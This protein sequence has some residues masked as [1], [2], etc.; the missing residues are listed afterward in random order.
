M[1]HK[2]VRHIHDYTSCKAA[3]T[4]SRLCSE[5]KEMKRCEYQFNKIAM[6]CCKCVA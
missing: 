4:E 6:D 3:E 5:T 2:Q 1:L